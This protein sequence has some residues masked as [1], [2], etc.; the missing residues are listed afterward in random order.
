MTLATRNNE[1][2]RAVSTATLHQILTGCFAQVAEE[3]DAEDTKAAERLKSAT[4][5]WMRHTFGTMN[6]NRNTPVQLIQ[7]ALGHA[8]VGTTG[9][10]LAA[11]RRQRAQV[12]NEFFNEIAR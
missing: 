7:A 9:I 4:T 10:Y 1:N 6:A 2:R 12:M 3:I 8:D 11:E 5:H